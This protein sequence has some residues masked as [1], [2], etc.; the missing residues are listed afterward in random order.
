MMTEEIREQDINDDDDL[1]M[2]DITSDNLPSVLSDDSLR[3][4]VCVCD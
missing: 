3:A 1:G 4:C 2:L